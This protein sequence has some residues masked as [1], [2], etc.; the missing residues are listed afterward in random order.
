MD[1][2]NLIEEAETWIKDKTPD[3]KVLSN[4]PDERK[5]TFSLTYS[6]TK[7][8]YVVCP[9]KKEQGWHVW[10]TNEDIL[11][12][13]QDT[14]DYVLSERQKTIS[15]ILARVQKDVKEPPPVA[16]KEDESDDD[17]CCLDDDCD[18][19]DDLD[20]YYNELDVDATTEVVKKK[21]PE[22]DSADAYFMGSGSPAAVQRLVKDLKNLKTTNGKFGVRGEPR[23]NNL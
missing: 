1:F 20:D 3:F 15:D 19:E 12:S 7:T 22:E 13:M 2:K 23:G 8:F 4:D 10:S 5:I 6:E 9:L 17:G 21:D 14:Q 18:D 16:A 11:C